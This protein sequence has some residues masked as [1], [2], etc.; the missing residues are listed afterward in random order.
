M[1]PLNQEAAGLVKGERGLGALHLKCGQN[2][3]VR[4]EAVG[5]PSLGSLSP[6]E[7]P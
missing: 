3:D 4:D 7:H 2:Q 1:N 6:W 5:W